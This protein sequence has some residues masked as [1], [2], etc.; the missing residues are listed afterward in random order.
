MSF[1]VLW[2]VSRY[3]FLKSVLDFRLGAA[4]RH[5]LQVERV[6]LGRA[7]PWV[8]SSRLGTHFWG[9]AIV[10]REPPPRDCPGDFEQSYG[11]SDGVGARHALA[12]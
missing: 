12:S 2:R 9:R 5:A 8:W 1:A 3:Q 10:S 6:G 7:S 11:G 4:S